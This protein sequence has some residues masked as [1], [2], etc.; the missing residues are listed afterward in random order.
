MSAHFH[1]LF[2]E[3]LKICVQLKNFLDFN[4]YLN[5]IFAVAKGFISKY[6]YEVGVGSERA[7]IYYIFITLLPF[8]TPYVLRRP[9]PHSGRRV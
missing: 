3:Y 7:A 1:K 2:R 4:D 5:S 8:S 9:P 6:K